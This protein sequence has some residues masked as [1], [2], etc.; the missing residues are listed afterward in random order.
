MED[1]RD[2]KG[3]WDDL[4]GRGRSWDS[5]TCACGIS[6]RRPRVTPE[7]LRLIAAPPSRASVPASVAA[8]SYPKP[9]GFG[10]MFC[11]GAAVLRAEPR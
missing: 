4:W 11:A 8:G 9:P 1:K 3:R 10:G 7:R 2:E 6:R 5:T